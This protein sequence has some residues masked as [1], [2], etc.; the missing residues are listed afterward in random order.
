M[1]LCLCGDLEGWRM[2]VWLMGLLKHTRIG[3]PGAKAVMGWLCD[4][5]R[6][7]GVYSEGVRNLAEYCEVSERTI[8]RHLK[9]LLDG[10]W[11]SS[12]PSPGRKTVF[13]IDTENLQRESRNPCQI[14]STDNMTVLTDSTESTDNLSVDPRQIDTTHKDIRDKVRKP[15]IRGKG[16]AAGADPCQIDT[17]LD[18]AGKGACARKKEEKEKPVISEEAQQ[19]FLALFGQ[20]ALNAR[21]TPVGDALKWAPFVY[22]IAKFVRSGHLKLGDVLEDAG[23]VRLSCESGSVKDAGALFSD[24]MRRLWKRQGATAAAGGT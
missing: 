7:D 16:E 5:A 8:E 15:L 9:Y 18:K 14:D 6:D 24:R 10:G 11:L 19:I 21:G 2:S 20:R 23:D 4:I 3:N 17:T 13:R 1:P 12:T 22:K